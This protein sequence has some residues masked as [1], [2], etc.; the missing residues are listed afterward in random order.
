M[1]EGIH[2]TYREVLVHDLSNDDKF[3]TRST[4]DTRDK[5]VFDG[6]E[7]PLVKVDISST[8]HPYYTGKAKLMDTAGRVDR[9]NKK[10]NPKA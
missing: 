8:S 9:F 10:Y 1:K 5:M 6:V 2:P 4:I 7:Y 3:I